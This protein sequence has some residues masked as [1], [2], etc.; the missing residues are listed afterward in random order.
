LGE[1]TAEQT[2]CLELSIDGGETLLNMINDLLDVSKMES[3]ALVLA[4]QRIAAP[5][6][7]ARSLQQI[8][9]LAKEKNVQLLSQIAP[10][11]P[12]LEGDVEKLGRTLVNLMGNAVKFT[13]EGGEITLSISHQARP[14]RTPSFV[15]SVSDNGEGIPPEDFERIFEKFGQV[16]KR[17][18]G[19]KMSTGLGLTFCKMVVEAHGGRIWLESEIG[20][21]SNFIFAIPHRPSAG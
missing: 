21:G 20:R 4:R 2:E 17:N 10:D 16:E 12:V 15:L 19:R 8:A 9:A 18:G 3:G 5:E 7:A 14:E 13:P 6:L 11:L 1:L